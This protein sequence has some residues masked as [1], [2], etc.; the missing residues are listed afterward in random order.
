M[1]KGVFIIS[2]DCEGKWGMAD[3]VTEHHTRCLTNANI[4]K[5]YDNLLRLLAGC[6]IKAT[7]A[8]VSLFTMSFDEY[9]HYRNMLG[10]SEVYDAWLKFFRRDIDNGLYDGWFAPGLMEL[11]A[12]EGMHEIA[13]HGFCHIPFDARIIT[14]TDAARELEAIASVNGARS[15]QART[16]VYPRNLVG[17]RDLLSETGYFGYREALPSTH[18]AWG[19]VANIAREFNLLQKSQSRRGAERLLAIPSGY[20]LNWRNGVRTVVPAAVTLARW[21]GIIDHAIKH[22]GIAHLWL[23]PHNLIDGRSQLELLESVLR[24]VADKLKTGELVNFTQ[25]DYCLDAVAGG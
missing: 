16:F 23:H 6:N 22:D 10:D 4:E 12:A 14:R 5:T 8:F 24:H 13:S 20:F 3:H 19:K 17:Y 18:G 15:I 7:F 9:Y 11:V 21:K 25:Y 1:G 2:L